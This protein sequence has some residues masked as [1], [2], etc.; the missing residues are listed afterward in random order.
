[1][2]QMREE[3][4]EVASEYQ[5]IKQHLN[6]IQ[7]DNNELVEQLGIYNGTH[8]H[9]LKT[10]TECENYENK[11]K[12]SLILIEKKKVMNIYTVFL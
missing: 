11:L 8:L 6:D 3:V 10:I 9:T 12:K 7:K 2:L 1:M 5:I 4:V